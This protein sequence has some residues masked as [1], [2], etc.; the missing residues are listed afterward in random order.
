MSIHECNSF[1][2]SQAAGVVRPLVSTVVGA[3]ADGF[4]DKSLDRASFRASEMPQG[5]RTDLIRQSYEKVG[6]NLIMN[7]G[8][9]KNT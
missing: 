5:F 1:C 6:E 4:L 3:D 7:K 2:V 9:G 8:K